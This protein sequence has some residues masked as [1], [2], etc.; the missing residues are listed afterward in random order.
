MQTGDWWSV[1]KAR[2]H[3]GGGADAEGVA[4]GAG[5]DAASLVGTE[6]GH[7]WEKVL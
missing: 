6:G 2:R 1:C 3:G 4:G 5:A 7:T